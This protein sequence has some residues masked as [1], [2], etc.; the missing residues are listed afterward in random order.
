MERSGDLGVRSIVESRSLSGNFFEKKKE[1]TGSV[2]EFTAS[3]HS[4]S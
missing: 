3:P 4:S 1:E 2:A